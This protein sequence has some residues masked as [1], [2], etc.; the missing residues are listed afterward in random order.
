MPSP[1]ILHETPH[2][3][4]IDK[5][6]G[7]SVE[8]SPHGYPSVE[9]WVIDTLSKRYRN[10]YVGIVHRLDR[11]TSGVLL[12][13]KKISALRKLNAQFAERQTKKIYHALVDTPP[14]RSEGRLQHYLGRNPQRRQ[15]TVSDK[16]GPNTKEAVLTY[17]TL[18]T[19]DKSTLL[20]I[21]P[22]HGR[23]H[24]IRAQLAHIGCPI[25]GDALY[26]STRSFGKEAIALHAAELHFRHPVS[27]KHLQVRAK[28]PF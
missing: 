26:G 27:G 5:P 1:S 12:V 28:R 20:E 24:Q 16:K 4:A 22:I 13:A 3:I 2:L 6:A 17:R 21:R 11:K 19:H 8:K 15:A 23:F 10:P 25:Q 14:P 7:M 9:Q 18:E